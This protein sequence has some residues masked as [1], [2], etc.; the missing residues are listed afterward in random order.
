MTNEKRYQA[1]CNMVLE[2]GKTTNDCEYWSEIGRDV[3]KS[4]HKY[5]GHKYFT[6]FANA[7]AL[8]VDCMEQNAKKSRTGTENA[9]IKRIFKSID[10]YRE[11]LRGV[12]EQSGKWI[13]TDSYRA[14]RL[15]EKPEAIP[16]CIGVKSMEDIMDKAKNKAICREKVEL[17]DIASIKLY[18]AEMK[19]KHGKDW[20]RHNPIEALPGWYCNPQYLLDIMQALPDGTAYRPEKWSDMLYYESEKGDAVLLPVKKA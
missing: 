12:F 2:Y 19:A 16:E 8:L 9:A 17:P 10:P 6:F 5:I 15:N 14:I 20:Q 3:I 4:P 7:A 18:I 11:N 13:I 1:I